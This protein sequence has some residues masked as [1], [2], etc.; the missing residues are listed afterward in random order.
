MDCNP[1][2]LFLIL[3]VLLSCAAPAFPIIYPP[4]EGKRTLNVR[5]CVGARVCARALVCM[6]R[7]S[8]LTAVSKFLMTARCEAHDEDNK[9]ES[10]PEHGRVGDLS[11][12]LPS[13]PG[14]SCVNG[15]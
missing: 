7:I 3:H 11:A 12:G 10:G 1:R 2:P 9:V 13:A 8:A 5:T 4:N 6:V 14:D 15:G